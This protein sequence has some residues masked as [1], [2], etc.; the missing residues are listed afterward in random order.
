MPLLDASVREFLDAHPSHCEVRDDWPLKPEV[1]SAT[2]EEFD[3][4][5]MLTDEDPS[6]FVDA[7]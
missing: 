7:G 3:P 2:G 4:T 1:Q 6:E 5:L